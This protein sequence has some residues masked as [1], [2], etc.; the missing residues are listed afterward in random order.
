MKLAQCDL[1]IE[2]GSVRHNH[3]KLR[4]KKHFNSLEYR[5]G[6]VVQLDKQT[7]IHC[8]SV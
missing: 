7:Y 4:K 3:L 5:E 8:R 1:F 6:Y 2:L